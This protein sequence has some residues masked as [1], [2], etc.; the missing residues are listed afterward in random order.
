M[1]QTSDTHLRAHN[2][3]MG[4][5]ALS[6]RSGW[7]IAFGIAL[8]ALGIVAF[9]SVVTATIVS[10]FFVGMMMIFAGVVEI[11][12][13]FQAK[14]WSRFFLWMIL[15]LAYAVAGMFAL[16]NPLLAAGV[17]TLLLGASLVAT[18]LLRIVL[19]F[20]MKAGSAWGWVA[21]SGAI[22]TAL[23]AM[24]LAQWPQSSLFI[25]GLFLSI[26]LVVAG[27]SWLSLGLALSRH[28]AHV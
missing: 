27:I 21:V 10:V 26:D 28:K 13:G 14:S 12:V 22:T 18:G 20:Q 3:G 11:A 9:G 25:L 19:A 4:L 7:I 8:V 17:L 5:H 23:G 24:I 6:A 1:S 15:G 16:A 2:P